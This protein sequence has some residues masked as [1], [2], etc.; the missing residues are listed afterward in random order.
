MAV[1]CIVV[2][3]MLQKLLIMC[4]MENYSENDCLKNSYIVYS[5]DFGQLFTTVCVCDVGFV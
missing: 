3:W 4:I 2:F 1:M 5:M